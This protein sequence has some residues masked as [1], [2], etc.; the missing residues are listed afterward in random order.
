MPGSVKGNRID[1]AKRLLVT[2]ANFSNR[3]TE[4]LGS[5]QA[6]KS[7]SGV[8]IRYTAID[9]L[10][11]RDRL[12]TWT[13]W[14]APIVKKQLEDGPKSSNSALE[15]PANDTISPAKNESIDSVI[16]SKETTD[17][18]EQK[19]DSQTAPIAKRVDDEESNSVLEPPANDT[20]T[21][22]KNESPDSAMVFKETT[23]SVEQKNNGQPAETSAAHD[24]SEISARWEDSYRLESSAL[25]G[26][27]LHSYDNDD[28]ASTMSLRPVGR[29][30]KVRR[31]FSTAVPNISTL[32]GSDSTLGARKRPHRTLI[33]QFQPNPFFKSSKTSKAVGAAALS[34]F[35]PVEM[36]FSVEQKTAYKLRD[37]LAVVSVGNSDLMLPES[38]SDVRFQQRSVSNLVASA[39][40]YP[41]GIAEFLR[42]SSLDLKDGNFD[43]PAKLTI[44]IAAHLCPVRGF[45]FMGEGEEGADTQ[46]VEYLFTGLEIRKTV[47]TFYEGWRLHYTSIEAG[48]AAGRRGELRLLPVRLDRSEVPATEEDFLDAAC[49]L[50]AGITQGTTRIKDDIVR[51]VHKPQHVPIGKILVGAKPDSSPHVYF[52]KRVD[53]RQPLE[54]VQD[55][56]KEQER[57]E[58]LFG[59][60]GDQDEFA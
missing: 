41:P 43:A 24:V 32:L 44:P 20:L 6:S 5:R 3:V 55:A 47:M 58:F 42:N 59:E 31:T 21:P 7:S 18:V 56:G 37:I 30:A 28:H 36:R 13:R 52:D 25:I 14:T 23:D 17:A 54:Q 51:T 22:T 19:N 11:W 15:P 60:G 45:Q 49:R 12:R 33:M 48:R 27:V 8:F 26:S 10:G 1:I 9:G 2:S 53:I 57:I 39:G 38:A 40:Q 35:P 46:D 16:A 50:A 29:T 4:W 34:V